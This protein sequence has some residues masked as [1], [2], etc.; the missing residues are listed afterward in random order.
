MTTNSNQLVA[1]I[2]E[3]CLWQF[4]SRA[5]DREENIRGVL[6][7]LH[8]LLTGQS[9]PMATPMDRCHFANA[10]HLAGEVRQAF[11]WVNQLGAQ[12]LDK[13]IGEAIARLEEITI[14]QSKNGELHMQAY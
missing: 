7:F 1:F 14:T 11:P 4:A 3:R 6:N 5:P 13:A 12:D 9:V 2:Q 8:L 10:N